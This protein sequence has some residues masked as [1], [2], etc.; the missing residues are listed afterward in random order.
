MDLNLR[1]C[2]MQK[3]S[4]IVWTALIGFALAV[5]AQELEV[6]ETET[7][8]YLIY[9]IPAEALPRLELH[10]KDDDGKP[11]RDF[12][13][14]VSHLH[15]KGKMVEFATN[16]GIYERG[17][18]PSGLTIAEGRELV[19]LNLAEGEGNFFLKPNGVFFV[20]QDQKP[21]VMESVEFSKSGIQARIATQSGPILLRRGVFHPA[22]REGSPNLRQRSAV[23]VRKKDGQVHFVMTDR[24]H[25][26][27]RTVNFHQLA[28][29]FLE[30]GCD[31]ALFLDGDI[32]DFAI[33]P[34]VET[35]FLPNTY[36]AMFVLIAPE[37]IG[38]EEKATSSPGLSPR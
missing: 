23:G 15:R 31:D 18:K 38:Q 33:R 28:T 8:R 13:A 37:P 7:T 21:G 24:N 17:P 22:F 29:F 3:P 19:P 36:A 16:G 9:R 20:D 34:T 5:S 26:S 2:F 12:G 1:A 35:R 11:L 6:L 14:L 30:Q 10:W 27:K 25:A 4:S 32:S